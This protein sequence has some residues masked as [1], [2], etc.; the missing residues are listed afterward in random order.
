[1]AVVLQP[2]LANRTAW[3]LR[4]FWNIKRPAQL[5][6]PVAQA[7]NLDAARLG[8]FLSPLAVVVRL[9]KIKKSPL[10]DA[11]QPHAMQVITYRDFVRQPKRN[12]VIDALPE[13]RGKDRTKVAVTADSKLA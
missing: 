5:P 10:P 2:I 1:M 4:T 3:R 9:R 6:P 12:R 13:L 7:G 11:S 8:N